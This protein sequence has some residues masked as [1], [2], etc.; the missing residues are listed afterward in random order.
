MESYQ[1]MHPA[2]RTIFLG[3]VSPNAEVADTDAGAKLSASL[4]KTSSLHFFSDVFL[5]VAQRSLSL[6]PKAP[7]PRSAGKLLLGA[8]YGDLLEPNGARIIFLCG[9]W[10]SGRRS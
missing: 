10:A 3:C 6:D 7:S 5:V 9:L 4:P 8:S 1:E 2:Q